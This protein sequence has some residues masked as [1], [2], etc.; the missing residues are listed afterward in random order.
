MFF[1]RL[2]EEKRK[3]AERKESRKMRVGLAEKVCAMTEEQFA[4]FVKKACE[5][6]PELREKCEIADII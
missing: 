6:F 5:Q 4:F 3:A 1:D 2:K